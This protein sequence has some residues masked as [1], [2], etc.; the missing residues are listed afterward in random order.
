M[1]EAARLL[2]AD[3][4]PGLRESLERMLTREGTCDDEIY[5]VAMWAI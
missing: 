4:D 5:H 1:S 2:V 3:D